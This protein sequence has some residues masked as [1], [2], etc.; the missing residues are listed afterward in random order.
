M[1]IT[2]RH[3]VMHES[4]L[5]G[6]PDRVDVTSWPDLGW[7]NAAY[8]ARWHVAWCRGFFDAVRPMHVSA[9]YVNFLGD[10]G[11]ERV[12]PLTAPGSSTGRTR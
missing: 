5:L 11:Q 4:P 9:L 8:T 3:A 12:P 10:H 6:R 1:T 7:Q 2:R